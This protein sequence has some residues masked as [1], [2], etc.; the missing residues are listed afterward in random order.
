MNIS[1]EAIEAAAKA[2]W[3]QKPVEVRMDGT[4]VP[5][6]WASDYFRDMYLANARAALEAA[7]PILVEPLARA[8]EAILA[9]HP[10]TWTAD[11]ELDYCPRC[12][13]SE[14]VNYP[15]ATARAARIEPTK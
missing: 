7:A 8:A 6:S 4:G 10:L 1:E 2:L 14:G 12:V 15:C 13:D 5:W 3:D 11:G 9:L